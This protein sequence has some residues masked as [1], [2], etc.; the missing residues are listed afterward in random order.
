MAFID[1]IK[2]LAEDSSPLVQ[3]A[4]ELRVAL[5]ADPNN[6]ESFDELISIIRLL[7]QQTPTADPLTADDTYSSKPPLNLV[8]LA[9]S[10][11]LASDLRAWYPLIQLAKITI[12]DDPAAAVHQI[13]VAAGREETGQALASGIK[14]LCEAGQPDTAMQV[15]LGRWLPDEHC[16]DVGLEL[17]RAAMA[18]DKIADAQSFLD[19]LQ[20]RFPSD[21]DVLDI[22]EELTHKQ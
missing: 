9:L 2:Q 7:G 12:D 16:I 3:R 19:V 15:G 10:E 22:V 1:L 6:A 17:I 4:G 8:L 18:S 11:D 14:L 20:K 21:H 13:E 5:A